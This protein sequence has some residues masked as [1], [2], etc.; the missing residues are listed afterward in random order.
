MGGAGWAAG[1]AGPCLG[2]G[3]DLEP[4]GQRGPCQALLLPPQMGT[5]HKVGAVVEEGPPVAPELPEAPGVESM[6]GLPVPPPPKAESAG[7]SQW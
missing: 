3:S 5:S 1:R 7:T 4:L 2:L 6:P